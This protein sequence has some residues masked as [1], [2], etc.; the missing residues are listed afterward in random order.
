MHMHMHTHTQ[1]QLSGSAELVPLPFS[2][3]LECAG[4][5]PHGVL[6]LPAALSCISRPAPSPCLPACSASNY[7]LGLSPLPLAPYLAG[8]VAGV[9]FWAVV[10]ASLGGASRS[11]LNHRDPDALLAD[12]MSKAGSYTR[13][14]TIAGALVACLAAAYFGVGVVRRQLAGADA[15]AASGGSSSAVAPGSGSGQHDLGSEQQHE[16]VGAALNEWRAPGSQ[17]SS[18]SAAVKADKE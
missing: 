17:P 13:E 11:M 5:I 2:K 7:V 3:P 8:T 16:L 9:G 15:S 12:L 1:Q 4:H 6:T 14:L 18:S 10:Y